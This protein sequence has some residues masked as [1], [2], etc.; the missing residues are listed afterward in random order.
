MA[1]PL[2][3]AV[4]N[5]LKRLNTDLADVP[6]ILLLGLIPKR[7]ENMYPH[8]NMHLNTHNSTIQNSQIRGSHLTVDT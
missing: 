1:R 8:K 2:L 6:E 3:E 4:W 5:I 7:S